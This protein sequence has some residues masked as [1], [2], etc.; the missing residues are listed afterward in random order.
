MKPPFESSDIFIRIALA[1]TRTAWSPT[2]S[3][4]TNETKEPR[5][6]EKDA[7]GAAI[8]RRARPAA[9][10]RI[11]DAPL[12]VRYVYVTDLHVGLVRPV[13]T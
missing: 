4:A 3:I 13:S 8:A 6:Y 7:V 12:A 1:S 9:S 5:P 2:G 10:V 11:V